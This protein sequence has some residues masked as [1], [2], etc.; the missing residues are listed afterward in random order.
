M[1]DA[2]ESVPMSEGSDAQDAER[3]RLTVLPSGREMMASRRMTLLNAAFQGGISLPSSCRNGT[4]R[5]CLCRLVAG[6]VSYRTEWPGVTKDE[7]AE[8]WI[9]PCVA[10]PEG[11]VTIDQPAMRDVAD[12]PVRPARSRG[13]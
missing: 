7:Q 13:F 11:D 1:A 12:I 3:V 6:R 8:G 10:L 9:L 2:T 4:C 5:A